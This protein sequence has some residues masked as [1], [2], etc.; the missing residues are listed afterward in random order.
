M[1]NV[2]VTL[3]L[4]LLKMCLKKWNKVGWLFSQC[5]SELFRSFFPPVYSLLV[6]SNK[7]TLVSIKCTIAQF[8][9][10]YSTSCAFSVKCNRKDKKKQLFCNCF[11]ICDCCTLTQHAILKACL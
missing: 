5:Q 3:L 2:S 9:Y 10:E 11:V 6:F 8:T 7:I 1:L 4:Y